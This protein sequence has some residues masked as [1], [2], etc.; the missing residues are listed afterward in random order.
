M[1]HRQRRSGVVSDKKDYE[2]TGL[3]QI[4]ISKAPLPAILQKSVLETRP[5]VP[6][7]DSYD[8]PLD[9]DQDADPSHITRRYIALQTTT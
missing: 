8:W 9:L 3:P 6:H 2:E 5:V 7:E 1:P 4:S